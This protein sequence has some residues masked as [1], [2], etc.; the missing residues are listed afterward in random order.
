MYKRFIAKISNSMNFNENMMTKRNEIIEM[1]K[2]GEISYFRLIE[3]MKKN[4]Y[5]YADIFVMSDR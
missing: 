2:T 3:I 5:N 1:E 4:I